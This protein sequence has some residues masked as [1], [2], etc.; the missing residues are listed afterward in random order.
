[1]CGSSVLAAATHNKHTSPI[2]ASSI[3]VFARRND[4]DILTAKLIAPRGVVP[5]SESPEPLGPK[6]PTIPNYLI[7][8]RAEMLQR[9]LTFA[10]SA[11]PVGTISRADHYCFMRSII[12]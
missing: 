4:A 6:A 1:M 10:V 11:C 12:C 3:F 2:T 7:I 9:K 8:Q 5:L